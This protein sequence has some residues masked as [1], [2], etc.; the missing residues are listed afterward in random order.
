MK[1]LFLNE[2][3]EFIKEITLETPKNY[4][5]WQHR[6]IIV[7]KINMEDVFLRDLE[8]TKVQLSLDAKN[9]HCWQYRQWIIRRS[10]DQKYFIDSELKYTDMLL[11]EDVYNNSAW[12][13]RY[14]LIKTSEKFCSDLKDYFLLELNRIMSYLTISYEDNECFWN[15][16]SAF[17]QDYPR[18]TIENPLYSKLTELIGSPDDSENYLYL[19]FMVRFITKDEEKKKKFCE[20]LKIL[21]PINRV[22]WA[23][24]S[25]N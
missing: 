12:N 19:K 14:F 7:E 16:L 25:Q 17:I 23:S 4:Q 11:N 13:H 3:L 20:K 6:Q 21:H 18:E 10:N 1:K 8:D 5:L 24:M 15:Y 2:E 22:L 9:I